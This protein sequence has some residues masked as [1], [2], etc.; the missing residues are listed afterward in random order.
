MNN[1]W[2]IAIRNRMTNNWQKYLALGLMV[3]VGVLIIVK[4]I[5]NI[6]SNKI[7]WEEGDDAN[8]VT[9]C[10]DDLG[11]MAVRFPSQ[12][13]E[14]CS[15]TT[16]TLMSHYAKTEYLLR[17][18]SRNEEQESEMLKVIADCYNAYQQAIFEA[19]TLD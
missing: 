8:M 18:E 10:L 9:E 3:L 6:Q 19:S 2:S 7:S 13:E 11:G 12:S 14:Y 17:L 15:C 5:Y 16:D 1:F 4:V